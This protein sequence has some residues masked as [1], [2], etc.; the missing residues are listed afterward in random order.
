MLIQYFQAVLDV[1]ARPIVFPPQHPTPSTGGNC[2]SH[3]ASVEQQ[4]LL[5]AWRPRCE[6][7]PARSMCWVTPNRFFHPSMDGGLRHASTGMA[8]CVD[9]AGVTILAPARNIRA[10]ECPRQRARALNIVLTQFLPHCETDGT[11]SILQI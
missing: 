7:T 1:S 6:P 3:L 2:R 5:G 8:F 10:C 9:P 11:F 4:G